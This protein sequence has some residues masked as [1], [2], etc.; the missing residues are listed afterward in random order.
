[1]TILRGANGRVSGAITSAFRYDV[2]YGS[3]GLADEI[4]ATP[5]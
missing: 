3:N 4:I 5:L 2:K 1:M